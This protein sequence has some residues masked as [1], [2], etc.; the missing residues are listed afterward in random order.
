[1]LRLSG[2]DTCIGIMEN[3]YTSMLAV[4]ETFARDDR[5]EMWEVFA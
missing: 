4:L 2:G 3:E 1:M 5:E